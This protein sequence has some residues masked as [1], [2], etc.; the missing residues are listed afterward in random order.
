[1][2]QLSPG[3]VI[4]RAWGIYRNQAGVLLVVAIGVFAIQA[5]ALMFF[6]ELFAFVAGIIGLTLSIFYQGMVVQ[7]VRDV[8]DGRRDHAAGELLRSVAPVFWQLLAIAILFGIAVAIG[9]VLLIVPGLILL[10]IWSVT[11]P[12]QVIERRGVFASFGRSRELVRGYGWPV[13]G[14]IVLVFLLALAVNIVAAIIA[15]PF[16]DALAAILGW[17]A[18]T[19][20]A[21]LAALTSSVLY[22]SLREAHGE[23]TDAVPADLGSDE[24]APGMA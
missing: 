22:F 20:V 8:Q 15:A 3:D 1:M 13:F 17:V 23:A 16:G 2:T 24:T 12:A 5:I 19:L 18:S 9:F 14:T 11:A 4:R 7:L 21:P 10:T 6:N